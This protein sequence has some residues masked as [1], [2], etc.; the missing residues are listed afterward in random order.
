MMALAIQTQVDCQTLASDLLVVPWQQAHLLP[1]GCHGD[2]KGG[3][4]KIVGASPSPHWLLGAMTAEE[5]IIG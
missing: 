3:S 5:E 1:L 2:E 4:V